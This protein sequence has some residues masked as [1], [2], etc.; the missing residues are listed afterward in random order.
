MFDV[1]E[2]NSLEELRAK[3][4]A[5]EGLLAQTP[6]AAYFQTPQWLETHWQFHGEKAAKDR[7]A[8]RLRVLFVEKEGQSV[9]ILP[10]AVVTEPFRVGRV[11]VLGYPLAG[12][13]SFY[14]P[15]GPRPADTLLAGLRHIRQTARD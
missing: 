7:P 15:I 13:G 6:K 14:G 5:W 3:R 2:I 10:L 11:R 8:G 9:G 4:A 1:I 12:W